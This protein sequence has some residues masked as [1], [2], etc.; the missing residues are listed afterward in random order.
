MFHGIH[1]QEEIMVESYACASVFFIIFVPN[2]SIIFPLKTQG[3]ESNFLSLCFIF[4]I[5]YLPPNIKLQFLEHIWQY[6]RLSAWQLQM[7]NASLDLCPVLCIPQ[8]HQL[9][10]PSGQV[11]HLYGLISSSILE[12]FR[13][14]IL[15]VSSCPSVRSST[16]SSSRTNGSVVTLSFLHGL[17]NSLD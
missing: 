14:L 6:I 15:I 10:P 12:V 1:D 4:N 3:Q 16:C 9:Q 11:R 7:A 17:R 13:I 2:I 8:F 5:I